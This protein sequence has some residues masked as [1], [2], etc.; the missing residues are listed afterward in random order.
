MSDRGGDMTTL[1]AE[2]LAFLRRAREMYDAN[3][4][5]FEFEDFA[6]GMRSP[7]FSKHR[8]HQNVL[9]H[10]LFEALETMWLDLGVRQGKVARGEDET[11][12]KVADAPRRETPRRR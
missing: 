1:T 7:L 4:S 2:E 11:T 9:K 5:W 3:I 12:Q 8:S 10:P 6:F